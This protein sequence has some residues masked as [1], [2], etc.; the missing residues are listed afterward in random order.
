MF[1]WMGTIVIQQ[2]GSPYQGGFF[3]LEITIPPNY[4]FRPPSISFTTKIFHPNVNQRG[5][6]CL[7]ILGDMWSPA[8]S[9]YRSLKSIESL[10]LK[11]NPDD[12][13]EPSIAMMYKKDYPKFTQTAKEWVIKYANL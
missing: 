8:S 3:F 11:P 6:H 4:P 12:P 2:E 10:I 9:I 13:L 5:R 7:D 1:H